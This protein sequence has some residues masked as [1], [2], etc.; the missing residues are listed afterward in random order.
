MKKKFL[1]T[2]EIKDF[3][4]RCLNNE[5]MYDFQGSIEII[6]EYWNTAKTVSEFKAMILN[7]KRL[8]NNQGYWELAKED[9]DFYYKKLS[10]Y[11]RDRA[12]ENFI[13]TSDIGSLSIGTKDF[14]YN[15][16]NCYGD[17]INNVFIFNKCTHLEC[18]DFLTTVEGNFNIYD[19]DCGNSISKTLKGRYG[20]YRGVKVF[21]FVKLD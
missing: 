16:S 17:G 6:K 11:L 7:D 10:I 2:N 3:T 14:K 21:V 8:E 9:E 1:Y 19:Y 12:D 20:I 5:S 18:L 13:T 4:K 15:I